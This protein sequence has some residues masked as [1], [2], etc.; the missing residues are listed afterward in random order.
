MTNIR[1]GQLNFDDKASYSSEVSISDRKDIIYKG[2]ADDH[3]AGGSTLWTQAG[4]YIYPT[5]TT[6]IVESFS[7]V[8]STYTAAHGT[9]I[10]QFANMMTNLDDLFPTDYV[11]GQGFIYNGISNPTTFDYTFY[12]NSIAS[13]VSSYVSVNSLGNFSDY[14][15]Y[16]S[17][18]SSD[19]VIN[20]VNLYHD[21]IN[22]N[23]LYYGLFKKSTRIV[24][25]LHDLIGTNHGTVSITQTGWLNL[26]NNAQDYIDY[27][28]SAETNFIQTGAIKFDLIPAYSGSPGNNI[29]FFSLSKA[30]S[31]TAN[32]IVLFH[33]NTGNI[34][35]GVYDS[36]GNNIIPPT[37]LAA[38]VPVSGKVYEFLLDVDITT[39]K[40]RLFINGTQLGATQ[41]QTGTRDSSIG[42]LR[43][44]NNCILS[45]GNDSYFYMANFIVYN[46]PQNPLVFSDYN[47]GYY[48]ENSYNTKNYYPSLNKYQYVSTLGA[49]NVQFG[50]ID[51]STI[52]GLL[53]YLGGAITTLSR[54]S[55]A[56]GALGNAQVP[57]IVMHG[58]Y[59]VNTDTFTFLTDGVNAWGQVITSQSSG[60]VIYKYST[61][62][63]YKISV[64]AVDLFVSGNI[65][66]T[67]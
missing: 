43:I 9:Q 50:E 36:A 54:T 48:L 55:L 7:G 21:L 65:Q 23:H 26:A 24:T 15:Y 20:A 51:T 64:K 57:L 62:S 40:T 34:V 17:S 18:A 14:Y 11:L 66:H 22:P 37:T 33:A 42:L 39:G 45:G 47:P 16:S 58:V 32:N 25:P 56:F 31:D 41:T 35:L 27:N 53:D 5:T 46:T 10:T 12:R 8:Q 29:F 52:D 44:G 61:A 67:L 28:V 1:T 30:A 63:I 38:W 4:G 49:N 59:D 2:Y 60:I 13:M 3:Y 6:S 19:V